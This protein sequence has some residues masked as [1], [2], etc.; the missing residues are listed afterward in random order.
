MGEETRRAAPHGACGPPFTLRFPSGRTA[1]PAPHGTLGLGSCLRGNG[2]WR[3]SLR[4]AQGERP[5]WPPHS[6]LGLGTCLRR[7][8]AW[9]GAPFECPQ[10][11]LR[12]AQGERTRGAGLRRGVGDAM[13]EE[14]PHAA[15]HGACG[16][17]SPFDFPQGER[18]PWPRMALSLWVP[19]FAGMTRVGGPLRVPSGQASTG[20][21]RT[22]LGGAATTGSRGCDGGG[23]APRPGPGFPRSR[24]RRWG[25]RRF[26]GGLGGG[27]PLLAPLGSCLRRN[28]ACGRVRVGRGCRWRRALRQAQGERNWEAPL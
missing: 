23:D 7:N 5:P 8:D 1:S 15:P 22:E 13:G 16:P 9:R 25:S 11:R 17:R 21:G 19:A 12:Q 26:E 3:G 18:P 28:D 6:T 27:A 2:A 10:D 20:S 4:Q 24:E 14:T